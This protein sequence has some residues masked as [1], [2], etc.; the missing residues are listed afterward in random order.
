MSD[1]VIKIISIF[2]LLVMAG[3]V[4]SAVL[5]D[6]PKEESIRS[7]EISTALP[8][9][10]P[11]EMGGSEI[12]TESKADGQAYMYYYNSLNKE[13][14]KVYE[15]M[16]KAIVERKEVKLGTKDKDVVS[17]IFECVTN[18]HPEIFYCNAYQ[19]EG[20]ELYG[21]MM[22][23]KFS[24]NYHM[25]E[26]EVQENLRSIEAY[27]QTCISSMPI[28]VDEYTKV[29]YVYEY[30]IEHTEYVPNSQNN[31]NICSVFIGGESVCM[32]YA[33]AT[34]Y[35][36]NQLG[37]DTTLAYGHVGTESHSWNLVR[38]DGEYYYM[39]P[40]WGDAGYVRPGQSAASAGQGINYEYFLITSEQLAKSHVLDNVVPLPACVATRNNYY[41]R[42]GL[43]LHGY[44]E[45]AIADIFDRMKARGEANVSL[46]C[47]D[48]TAYQD[49]KYA[50]LTEQNV[51]KFMDGA[52][53]VSYSYNDDLYTLIFWIE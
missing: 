7:S 45:I 17:K 31:Q 51:F 16:Y 43:F 20:M 32:G 52:G 48:A 6:A 38:V 53:T 19:I 46:R 9:S 24:A 11:V 49:V 41:I 3:M 36:L 42:E 15:Q 8:V 30:I 40:T 14:Q 23:I 33:K 25:T 26:E 1:K 28:G 35:I 10:E 47:S 34:Q 29:K 21:K 2:S 44:D 18:D 12:Q 37:I 50:L 22:Q 13:E 39:D 4:I 27:V 5:P